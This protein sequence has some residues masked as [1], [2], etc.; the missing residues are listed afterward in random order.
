MRLSEILH[1]GCDEHIILGLEAF[2]SPFEFVFE[3]QKMLRDLALV[4]AR[5]I[6]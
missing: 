6:L 2:K 4:V 1:H 5:Q 3:I